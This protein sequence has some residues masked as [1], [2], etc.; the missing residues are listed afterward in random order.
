MREGGT[1]SHHHGVGTDHLDWI[2]EEHGE[3]GL[4][5]VERLKAAV[6]PEGIMNPGKVVRGE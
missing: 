6:D 1:V 4:K 2:P 3:A 5:V